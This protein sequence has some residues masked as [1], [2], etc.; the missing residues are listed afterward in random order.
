VQK[1]QQ[2]RNPH[3]NVRGNA[4]IGALKR[5]GFISALGGMDEL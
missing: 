5:V 4:G 3:L 1:Q 2:R